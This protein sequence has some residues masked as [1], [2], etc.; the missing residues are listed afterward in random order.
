Y[1]HPVT[2]SPFRMHVFPVTN[3]QYELFDPAHHK[4][5]WGEE[6]HP[7]G[8]AARDDPVVYV[9]WYQAWC[10]AQWTGN[11]LPTEAQWEYGC[12]GGAS[13]YQTFHFGDSLSSSQANFD[14]NY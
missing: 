8:E 5:R 11:H 3:A 2:M 12:R 4:A 10:F 6:S 7:A 13:S 14:G 1:Q 9:T